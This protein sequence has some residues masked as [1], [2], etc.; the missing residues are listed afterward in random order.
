MGRFDLTFQKFWNFWKVSG[1]KFIQDFLK[2]KS[3]F[4]S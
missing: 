1:E 3:Y 4:K 2:L